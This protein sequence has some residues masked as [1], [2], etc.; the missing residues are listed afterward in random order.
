MTATSRVLGALAMSLAL[1]AH[2]SDLPPSASQAETAYLLAFI[3]ASNCEFYRNGTGY[4][5][6]RA[7]SH[8]RDKFA[9]VRGRDG[10]LTAEE[11]I[12][13]VASISSLTGRPYQVSCAGRDR[14]LLG[15]WLR[16]ALARYR[17]N[18]ASRESRDAP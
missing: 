6:T 3:E 11:F 2:A 13:K 16:E 14:V 5:G 9:A 8:L 7:G 15:P 18:G 17:K 4:D 12:E 10:D 1:V